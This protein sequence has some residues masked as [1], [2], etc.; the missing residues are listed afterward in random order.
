MYFV[1]LSL[2]LSVCPSLSGLVKWIYCNMV[3][4]IFGVSLYL[5]GILPIA[6][7][8]LQLCAIIY[9]VLHLNSH[10]IH[11]LFFPSFFS[12]NRNDVSLSVAVSCTI[13][14]VERNHQPL[15]TFQVRTT[16]LENL[17]ELMMDDWQYEWMNE[18]HG[19]CHLVNSSIY[20]GFD[21]NCF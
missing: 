14:Y 4:I 9:F 1:F 21:E 15:H 5:A 18:S 19:I 8:A 6:F 10:L 7:Y 20:L 12:L 2:P 3:S 16:T 17:L 11:F 13:S